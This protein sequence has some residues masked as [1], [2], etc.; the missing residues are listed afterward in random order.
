MLPPQGSSDVLGSSDFW[1]DEDLAALHLPHVASETAARK[2]SIIDYASSAGIPPSDL[3]HASWLVTSRCLTV[4]GEQ[5]S[6]ERK[7][8]LIPFL[9]MCNHDRRSPHVL[10]GRAA[11]GGVL[12]VLAGKDVKKGEQIC[13]RYGGGGEGNDR[14]IQ[15][16]GFVDDCVEAFDIVAKDLSAAC[17]DAGFGSLKASLGGG[18]GGRRTILKEEAERAVEMIEG[19]GGME[20]GGGI[21]QRVNAG[22]KAAWERSTK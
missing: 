5:D 1:S 4:E 14:F 18:G 21:V 15:D 13:I 7:K 22:L 2:A 17:S 6:G 10:T 8:L 19:G 16:Y 11:D 20:A 3:S 12:K 9:D